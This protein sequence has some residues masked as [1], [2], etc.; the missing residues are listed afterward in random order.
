MCAQSH[1]GSEITYIIMCNNLHHP[2]INEFK[3][4]FMSDMHIY[5]FY[6]CICC[7]SPAPLIYSSKRAHM[8][9]VYIYISTHTHTWRERE[10]EIV[11]SFQH[12]RQHE[13]EF[14]T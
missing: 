11:L 6:R 12:E 4:L 5:I 14:M 1:N 3:G 7:P 8:Y 2:N 13:I 9:S 10:R